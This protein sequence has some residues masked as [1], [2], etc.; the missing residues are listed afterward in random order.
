MWEKMGKRL[1]EIFYCANGGENKS[2]QAVSTPISIILTSAY[3]A[4]VSNVKLFN[5]NKNADLGPSVGYGILSP[6]I[7]Y[8]P[9]GQPL[10]TI[11][12]GSG[13][14]YAQILQMLRNDAYKIK[15]IT[16][17]SSNKQLLRSVLKINHYDALG[18]DVSRSVSVNMNTFQNQGDQIN[19]PVNFLLDR[20]TEIQI[21]TL[22]AYSSVEYRFYPEISFDNNISGDYGKS[23]LVPEDGE[24]IAK[25]RPAYEIQ[26]NINNVL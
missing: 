4:P 20:G 22:P 2:A 3:Y 6:Y 14:S 18:D 1:S 11:T 19:V 17:I 23:F 8:D 21:A 13:I 24:E 25:K 9:M 16:V 7:Y 12:S 26:S 5:A 15:K 10:I